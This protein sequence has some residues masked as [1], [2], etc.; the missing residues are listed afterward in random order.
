MA[1]TCQAE[2]R[3]HELVFFVNGRKVTEQ[4]ADPEETLL[5]YLRKKLHLTGS[6]Y[7]CGEGGCGACTIMLSRYNAAADSIHHYAVNACLTPVCSVHGLAVTTVEGV[8]S[9]TRG[10]H[11]IQERLVKNHGTQCGFCTPG[12]VM[13]MYTLLRNTPKPPLGDIERV[14]DGNLCRCTGY[15][16]ILD[17]MKTF[18]K[19]YC[20]RG[21][22]C[23]R[24]QL[25]TEETS[26]QDVY[27]ND[28]S[29]SSDFT[30]YDSTQEPIFPPELQTQHDRYHGQYV[31]FRS[32][33][34]TWFRPVNLSTLLD[35]KAAH[36]QARLIVGNTEVGVEMKCKHMHY[37][38]FIAVGHVP[39][40][41]DIEHRESGLKIGAS[42]T[43]SHLTHTLT[44]EIQALPEWKTRVYAAIVEMLQWF[45]GHQIR[46]AAAVGGNITTASP[47]SDL[48]PLFL[49][50]GVVLEV[51]SR[52]GG[53]RKI[54]MDSR[55]FKGYRKTEIKP[56]EVLVSLTIPHTKKEEFFAGFK[57]ANRKDDDISIVNSGM[58]VLLDADSDV[59]KEIS[60]AFGGMAPITVMAT[61]TMQ[62]LVGK[63]WDENL[64]G[65]AIP[66][67]SSDLP[68][69]AGSPGGN[70]EYRSTLTVSFFFKFYLAVKTQLGKQSTGAPVPQ[71]YLSAVSEFE[72]L[73]RQSCQ[74]YDNVASGQPS[75][76]AVGRPLVHRAAYQQAT[77]EAVYVD[78]MPP[79]ADELV[80]AL[81]TSTRAHAKIVSIDASDA[82]TLPGV[83]DFICQKDVP[84][85][86]KLQLG[87][88]EIFASSEVSC[89]GQVIGAVVGDCQINAQ[90]G[91]RAVKVVYEDLDAIITIEEAVAKNSFYSPSHTI[92]HG[93]LETGFSESDHV[94]E[95][96]VR[97]GAQEH[98][99]IETHG[100][101]AIPKEDG[102]MELFA[103]TQNPSEVQSVISE[104]LGVPANRI[105][106]RTKRLGGGFGG[107]E[108]RTVLVSAPVAVA[109]VKHRHP[110]RCVLDR[111]ED[112]RTTGTRHP[113][114][115]KYKIGFTAD[116]RVMA[117]E[118]HLYSNC[119]NS[120]DVSEAVMDRAL[121]HV[122]N[123]YYIPHIR[124]TGHLC[125]TNIPSC[126][127]YR[128]FGAP[129]AMFVAETWITDVADYLN[130]SPQVVREKNLFKEG[131]V[132]PFNLPLTKCNIRRCWEECIKQS[133]YD[134]RRKEVDLHNSENRWK[135][136]GLAVTP[137]TFGIGFGVWE[138]N[139]GGALVHVYK[140]GSV[141]VAHG[142]IEMGQG[143]HTKMIQV[144]SRALRI[145]TS[146]IHIT[147][148]STVTVPNTS[149]S[150]ASTCSDLNGMAIVNACKEL[151]DRL[152]P[153]MTENPKGSWEDWIKAAYMKR[154]SLS[155]TGFYRTPD[156]WFDWW[157][158]VGNPFGYYTFG[159]ACSEVEVDCL[160]GDHQVLRT[161]IV[162][163]VGS[164]LNPAIDIGQIEGAFVQ[165]YGML[166]LEQYKVSP[167]GQLITQGPGNYKIPSLGNIPEQ[168]NVSLLRGSLNQRAVYSSKAIGEPPLFLA[169]SV[170]FAI[171][172]AIK[173]A[174]GDAGRS[175]SFRLDSPAS[176]ARIRMACQDEFTQHYP[177]AQDG[178]YTP[179]FVDL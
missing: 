134:R 52:D 94:L 26:N 61:K 138:L 28:T 128:G 12:M 111:D 113:F 155:A 104:V 6:K 14:F 51:A 72:R 65:A 31:V 147:E 177:K 171:K 39:E 25:N 44:Q 47:I 32:A 141:L 92:K 162:M 87:Q 100:A 174:R 38:Q 58:R 129:Q 157:K 62:Q 119:G 169:S 4:N 36:P 116:G 137:V 54:T 69:P 85:L 144:T 16:P 3:P 130:L 132:T 93:D 163:D 124:A 99:Y 33:A 112:M 176:A 105:T 161:D 114:K 43:L 115:G 168:F 90:R 173:S 9:T 56:D 70:V 122:D 73:P 67:L 164:S 96:E 63:S 50:A 179:W 133:Q 75:T 19:E 120:I 101:L 178:S 71:S 8:G 86:N 40:L 110:V 123:S 20:Q 2:E 118:L 146:K 159:V 151:I 5:H 41:T 49:A 37:P 15:R 17:G 136:K 170:F 125:K 109:A 149:P 150:A 82:L 102:E 145:P 98:F 152:D 18:S 140:D 35:L 121:L 21:D 59:I 89:Q 11:P 166:V 78:D 1:T 148:T 30:P 139:Q 10:L 23:C 135:K 81:V 97:S 126:T 74:L 79:L 45:G 91:A 84:G 80:L 57:Q 68:L 88:E 29:P 158:S 22:N 142:G 60:L 66:Y 153:V 154:I 167:K 131:D 64:V 55:F 175:I 143:L 117:L 53:W 172:D 103:A 77:G 108:T 7:G 24:N 42:V 127:A 160:T 46:N 95:G 76:D 48:N 13:S 83:V 34:V 165:G 106:V 156:L 107:K 27:E